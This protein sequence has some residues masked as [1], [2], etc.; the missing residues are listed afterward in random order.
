MQQ[1]STITKGLII[2]LVMIAIGLAIHF[3][4]IALDSPLRWLSYCIFII[5]IIVSILQYGKQIDHNATFGNYFAHGFKISATV[6]VIMVIYIIVFVA[7]FPDFKEK[8]MDEAKKAMESQ[9]NTEE[10]KT[11]GMEMVK[12]LFM[13]FLV[14][15]TLIYNLIVGAISSLI[16]AAVTRK[17]PRPLEEIN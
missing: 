13:V 12:K 8:A 4:G 3:S 10:Q 9:G 17:N 5:G 16:G 1:T 2:A 11:Q 15:G 14:G 7:L 6:T